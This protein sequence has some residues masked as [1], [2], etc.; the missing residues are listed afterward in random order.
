M[1]T[2]INIFGGPGS[3]KS[4]Y[5]MWLTAELKKLGVNVE[6]VT[7]VAKDLVYEGRNIEWLTQAELLGAQSKRELRLLRNPTVEAVITDSPVFLGRCFEEFY[8]KRTT[9][10]A[11][12][13][14]YYKDLKV[15]V[16]NVVMPSP[17]FPYNPKGRFEDAATAKTLHEFIS[18]KVYEE[19]PG[20]FTGPSRQVEFLKDEIIYSGMWNEHA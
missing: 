15:N 20:S 5:A 13:E 1:K 14:Q 18:T 3:G 16:I 17:D 19:M 10:Q 8:S 9:L 4:T 11:F 6:L 7:E 2:L 12:I